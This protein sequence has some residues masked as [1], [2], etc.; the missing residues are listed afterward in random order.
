MVETCRKWYTCE[1][2]MC[3]LYTGFQFRQFSY[4]FNLNW[5]PIYSSQGI[6]CAWF[7][8]LLKQKFTCSNNLIHHNLLLF[9]FWI[10][11]NLEEHQFLLWILTTDQFATLEYKDY[12]IALFLRL[13]LLKIQTN[14]FLNELKFV[15]FFFNEDCKNLTRGKCDYNYFL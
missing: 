9:Y 13:V 1:S 15:T 10:Q 11:K 6:F 14:W 7:L 4:D 2:R 3:S 5:L 12:K 8:K